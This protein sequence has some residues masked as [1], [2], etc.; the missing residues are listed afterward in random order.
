MALVP[1]DGSSQWK[2]PPRPKYKT[3]DDV[4]EVTIDVDDQRRWKVP[5]KEEYELGVT[6][7]GK[8]VHITPNLDVVVF[9]SMHNPANPEQVLEEFM[10]LG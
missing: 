1:E 7:E 5:T 3:A 8:P 4:H 2:T 9:C 10:C 6:R